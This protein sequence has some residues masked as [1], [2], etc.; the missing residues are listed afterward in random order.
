M[1]LQEAFRFLGFNE[2]KQTNVFKVLAAILHLGN[3]SFSKHGRDEEVVVKDEECMY[4]FLF[5]FLIILIDLIIHN[6]SVE[7]YRWFVRSRP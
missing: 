6:F 2:E 4:L 7:L 3:L 5:H 1:L